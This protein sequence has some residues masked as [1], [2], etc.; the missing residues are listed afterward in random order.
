MLGSSKDTVETHSIQRRR[1]V[2]NQQD[3]YNGT[4]RTHTHTHAHAHAHAHTH[5]HTHT[6]THTHTNVLCTYTYL[7][8]SFE[9]IVQLQFRS[10]DWNYLHDG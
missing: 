9:S 1:R 6:H 3:R 8:R 7:T 5:I 10:F 4:R 2:K